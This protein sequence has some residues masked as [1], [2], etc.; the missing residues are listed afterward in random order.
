M[1]AQSEFDEAHEEVS[2]AGDAV[3]EAI[4]EKERAEKA[5]GLKK[6]REQARQD[7][8]KS[9][10]QKSTKEST[11]NDEIIRRAAIRV[12]AKTQD[13]ELKREILNALRDTVVVVASD[14]DEKESRHEEGK[15]VDVGAWL[16]Q[17]GGRGHA[18]LGRPRGHARLRVRKGVL[19]DVT[20]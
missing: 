20:A 3:D 19:N 5:E 15:E 9:A 8:M 10:G 6:M 14:H 13:K 17:N 4:R 2:E 16:K 12:A 11:M 1:K 18:V 7:A